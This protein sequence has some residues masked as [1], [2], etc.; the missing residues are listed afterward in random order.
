[1]NL[2]EFPSVEA[3]LASLDEEAGSL[4]RFPVRFI[5]VGGL[6][7]WRKLVEGLSKECRLLR[8]STLCPGPDLLPQA[9]RLCALL[10]DAVE[11]RLLVLPYGELLRLCPHLAP[12]TRLATWEAVGPR[13]VYVPVLGASEQLID[14]LQRVARYRTGECA[15]WSVQGDGDVDVHVTPF[16]VRSQGRVVVEGVRAYLR[17]WEDDSPEQ[18]L[19][20]T[21]LAP[22]FQSRYSQFEFAVSPDA[23]AVLQSLIRLATVQREWGTEAQWEWLAREAR[24]GEDLEKVAAHLLN[25]VQYNPPQL[26]ATWQQLSAEH[27]WLAWLWARARPSGDSFADAVF[28]D[29]GSPEEV[30]EAACRAPL[31]RE[32][33]LAQLAERRKTLEQLNVRAMPAPFW[34]DLEAVPDALTRLKA[35]LDLSSRERE[36]IVRVVGELLAC[37][38]PDEEWLPYLEVSFPDLAAYLTSFPYSDPDVRQY[39][40]A[41]VRSRVTD[42]ADERLAGLSQRWAAE[43]ELW[44]YPPRANVLAAAQEAGARTIWVDAMGMEWA[45]LLHALLNNEQ[46]EATLAIARADLPSSTPFNKGWVDDS[47]VERQLDKIAHDPE[48]SY[49]AALVHEIDWVRGFAREVGVACQTAPAVIITSDHGLTRFASV[50]A[51]VRVP[52]G[53]EVHKLGR[54]ATRTGGTSDIPD[55][56]EW[57]V[58]QGALVLAGH[59]LFEGGS[60]VRG[61]VHGGATPE[62]ALVPVVTVRL[63]VAA[64]P[65]ARLADSSLRLDPQGRGELR[66]ELDAP[67]A[68]LRLV[69]GSRVFDGRRLDGNSWLV[70][71]EGLKTGKHAGRLEYEKGTIGEITLQVSRGMTEDDMGL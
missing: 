14:Q 71:I 31:Q 62:E 58:Q 5:L 57:M 22:Q 30:V 67:V 45:G 4:A 2:A 52:Q 64:R 10:E 11:E 9:G 65:K 37:H 59:C 6:L 21:S 68:G 55:G 44:R 1:M 26:L 25:L 60:G 42:K 16:T 63:R 32:L 35:L 15:V 24:P 33:T 7:A 43:K 34:R 48:Y 28:H 61:E 56:L 18:V 66:V 54:Y 69:V 27:R 39:M 40:A 13:R 12:T 36:E 50:G 20:V 3:L 23:Y 29:A 53:F 19:L 17:L 8:L 46:T 41:Y 38:T 47:R 51:R 49:P 70:P